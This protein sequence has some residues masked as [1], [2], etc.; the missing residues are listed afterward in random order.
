M[1][2]VPGMRVFLLT[3]LSLMSEGKHETCEKI[4]CALPNGLASALY[5]SYE[6]SFKNNG[7]CADNLKAIDEYFKSFAGIP[8]GEENRKYAC[9]ETNGLQLVIALVLNDIT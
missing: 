9:R 7:F 5:R 1:K 3:V 8:N 4:E 2:N 6:D